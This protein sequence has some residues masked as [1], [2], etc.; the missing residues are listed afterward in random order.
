MFQLGGICGTSCLPHLLLAS[1]YLF[2][3]LPSG[4]G[5]SAR[6]PHTAPHPCPPVSD[7]AWLMGSTV[8]RLRAGG[9]YLLPYPST[10][11]LLHQQLLFIPLPAAASPCMFHYP[12][13]VFVVLLTSPILLQI[14]FYINVSNLNP[15]GRPSVYII[16]AV[17]LSRTRS[18]KKHE[19]R[20][21]EK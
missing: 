7:W 9:I 13:F 19:C 18:Y 14:V 21:S 4:L 2:P 5:V 20:R 10:P 16:P 6:P 17:I 11:F 3:S 1:H 12:S 8:R 15:L